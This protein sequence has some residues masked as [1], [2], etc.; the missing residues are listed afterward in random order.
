[1]RKVIKH[2]FESL[3]VS[4]W[5]IILLAAGFFFALPLLYKS[6]MET[7]MEKTDLY[8]IWFSGLLC[9]LF[10]SL[11][12]FKVSDLILSIGFLVITAVSLSLVKGDTNSYKT[13]I[14]LF[15]S[16]GIYYY[17]SQSTSIKPWILGALVPIFLYQLILGWSQ[18]VQFYGDS[19]LI[20]GSFYNSGHFA[21]W[22]AP[23]VVILISICYGNSES[24]RFPTLKLWLCGIICQQTTFIK[25]GTIEYERKQ[26]LVAAFSNNPH[27]Q[28][29]VEKNSFEG[30][31]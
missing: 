24:S 29:F 4:D 30:T 15:F 21:N 10:V 13:L 2:T 31:F 6:K 25:V 14:T 26:N 11:E 19:T 7:G 18:I 17:I 20:R 8:L 3:K 5:I 16:L 27:M 9:W 12:K 23:F 28:M 1:M 22:L